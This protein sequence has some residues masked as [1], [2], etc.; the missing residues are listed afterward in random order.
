MR[1]LSTP[2]TQN[3]HAEGEHCAW[4]CM[5]PGW[6]LAYTRADGSEEMGPC[7]N[8]ERGRKIEFG[9][10]GFDQWGSQGFW[11]GRPTNLVR[12][13]R[14]N[15]P[16]K[17]PPQE[18]RAWKDMLM[19]G[20]EDVTPAATAALEALKP[21][22]PVA[23]DDIAAGGTHDCPTYRKV[24]PWPVEECASCTPATEEAEITL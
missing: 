24:V 23:D 9:A 7:P 1:A 10:V 2:V 6:V 4:C 16:R 3:A 18:A 19:K 14:C 17:G 22:Q 12:S 13:C 15:E 8:C 20:T 5:H 11:R 21:S